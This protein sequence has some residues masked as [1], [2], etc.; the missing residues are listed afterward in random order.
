MR[1]SVRTGFRSAG[2]RKAAIRAAADA[3]ARGAL[4][5]RDGGDLAGRSIGVP[6]D[7]GAREAG[8]PIKGKDAAS[9]I[10]EN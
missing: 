8:R 3:V 7:Q 9:E 2:L 6:G 4:A 1:L 5:P 10:D